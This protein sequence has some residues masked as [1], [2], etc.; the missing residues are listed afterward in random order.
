VAPAIDA[1]EH[2]LHVITAAGP[3]LTRQWPPAMN[4]TCG[5]GSQ[6][7]TSIEVPIERDTEIALLLPRLCAPAR[8]RTERACRRVRAARG[9]VLWPRRPFRLLCRGNATG[10]GPTGPAPTSQGKIQIP[11]GRDRAARGNLWA[12]SRI[13]NRSRQWPHSFGERPAPDSV[14][15]GTPHSFSL[16]GSAIIGTHTFMVALTRAVSGAAL[17]FISPGT[18][19]GAAAKAGIRLQVSP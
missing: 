4:S 8:P 2:H 12:K 6:P 11:R 14:G 1:I 15:K 16:R 3:C 9:R 10:P 17:L 18:K 7:S 5:S 13:P 19:A